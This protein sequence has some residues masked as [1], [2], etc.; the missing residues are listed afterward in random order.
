MAKE[1][2]IEVSVDVISSVGMSREGAV[3]VR[4]LHQPA[5]KFTPDAWA[6]IVLEVGVLAKEIERLRA[7]KLRTSRC[8]KKGG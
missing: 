2:A 1:A 4:M 8:S 5:I 3:T 6:W 7:K